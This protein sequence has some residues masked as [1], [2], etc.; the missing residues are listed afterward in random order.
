MDK[1]LVLADFRKWLLAVSN[2]MIATSRGGRG[3]DYEG[4]VQELAQEGYIA[5]WRALDTYD[6]DKGALAS[7]LVTAAE[8]RMADVLR[9]GT[10]FGQVGNRPPGTEEGLRAQRSLEELPAPEIDELEQRIAIWLSEG[11]AL[12]YH[13]GAIHRAVAQLTPDERRYVIM[14]FWEGKANPEIQPH[15]SG[16][17]RW[18]WST[19]KAKL[20]DD[21]RRLA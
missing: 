7:W 4:R 2:R 21:L 13:R 19:A 16:N 12:A 10:S 5:M 3:E 17:V 14:R 8:L 9:R 6:P 18:L 20:R 1:N 11:L 15:V